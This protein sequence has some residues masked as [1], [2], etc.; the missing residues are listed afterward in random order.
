MHD[1]YGTTNEYSISHPIPNSVFRDL[2]LLYDPTH[3]F[4]NIRN[5]WITEKTKSLSFRDPTSQQNITA[6]WA[7][8]VEL[9]KNCSESGLNM[10]KLSYQTLYPDRFDKQMVLLVVNVFNE[11]TVAA[12]KMHGYVETSAFVSRITRM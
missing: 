5:N 4:K 8:L 12:L 3:L 2:F 1:K 11:K 6:K 7:D 9:Y 10:T